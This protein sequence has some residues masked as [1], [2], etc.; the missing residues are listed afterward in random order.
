MRSASTFFIYSTVKLPSPKISLPIQDGICKETQ[1][2]SLSIF[3]KKLKHSFFKKP[4][5]EN[6]RNSKVSLKR[7]REK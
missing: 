1:R 7:S 5:M 3:Y 2:K 4:A 6:E